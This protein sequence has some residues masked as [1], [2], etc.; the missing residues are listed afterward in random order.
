MPLI[1]ALLAALSLTMISACNADELLDPKIKLIN[2]AQAS[3]LLDQCSR[4]VPKKGERYF[5]P[6]IIEIEAFETAVQ[7]AIDSSGAMDRENAWRKSQNLPQRTSVTKDWGRDIIGLER[8]GRRFIYGNYYPAEDRLLRGRIKPVIV[9]DGG[10]VFFGAEFDL[11]R[12]EIVHLAFNGA[13]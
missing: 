2:P 12:E 4:D 10:P 7:T 8:G 3:Q 5:S 13:L 6:S 1:K 9:C 11:E